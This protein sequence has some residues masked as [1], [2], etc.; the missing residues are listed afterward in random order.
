M[1]DISGKEIRHAVE[2]IGIDDNWN[3][4]VIDPSEPEGLRVNIRD[5]ELDTSSKHPSKVAA[6][7]IHLNMANSHVVEPD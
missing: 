5:L 7:K 3:L 1:L 4:L 2:L 6:G